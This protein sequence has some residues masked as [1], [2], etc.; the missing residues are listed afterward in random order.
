MNPLS[1]CSNS[2]IHTIINEQWHSVGLRDLVQLL[3]R[4]DQDCSII[5][6]VSVL[7]NGDACRCASAREKQSAATVPTSSERLLDHR[8]QIPA[9]Q[10]GR[11]R[12]SDQVQREIERHLSDPLC[13][14]R[15]PG[16]LREKAKEKRRRVDR[17]GHR[18]LRSSSRETHTDE[19]D[20]LPCAA[21]S[22]NTS[23]AVCHGAQWQR[24]G[25]SS[26]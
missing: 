22:I 21:L 1:A 17:P 26:Q 8:T 10:N 7:D 13:L 15:R 19:L 20:P 18:L 11:G 23:I 25:G 6:F 12:V 3:G 16:Q 14:L 5:Y 24:A 2:N 9:L 4:F